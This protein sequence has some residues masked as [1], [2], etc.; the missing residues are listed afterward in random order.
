MKFIFA[1]T[2]SPEMIK[3]LSSK[4]LIAAVFLGSFALAA[5]PAISSE[6]ISSVATGRVMGTVYLIDMFYSSAILPTW[7]ASHEL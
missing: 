3:R 1:P 6:H 7:H 5:K 4:L 2:L